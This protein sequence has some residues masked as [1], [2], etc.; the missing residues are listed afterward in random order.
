MIKSSSVDTIESSTPDNIRSPDV[1]LKTTKYIVK[2]ILDANFYVNIPFK[3][4]KDS[5]NKSRAH[6]FGDV[7]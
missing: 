1:L 7:Y 4:P 2:R 5:N 6:T 3:Y